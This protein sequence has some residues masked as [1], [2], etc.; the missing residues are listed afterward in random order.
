MSKEKLAFFILFQSLK[1]FKFFN[2]LLKKSLL[3]YFISFIKM[4]KKY[5]VFL[6]NFLLW[7]MFNIVN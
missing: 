5:Y 4:F 6:R 2:F 1:Y 7:N 3:F